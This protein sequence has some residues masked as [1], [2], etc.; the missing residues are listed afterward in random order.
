MTLKTHV[1]RPMPLISHASPHQRRLPEGKLPHYPDPILTLRAAFEP[2]Q[3]EFI[4]R[5]AYEANDCP[6]DR[7]LPLSYPAIMRPTTPV[8]WLTVVTT[9]SMSTTAKPTRKAI[10]WVFWLSGRPRTASI[11]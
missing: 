1:I 2:T 10:S 6:V 9:N 8:R 5:V 3:R 11:A 4:C 7:R